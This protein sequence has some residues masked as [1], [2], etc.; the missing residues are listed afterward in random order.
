[1]PDGRD[2]T[3]APRS[4][5]PAT[6]PLLSLILLLGMAGTASAQEGASGDATDSAAAETSDP[7]LYTGAQ[8]ERGEAAFQAHCSACHFPNQF[9][10]EAF[11]VQWEG[12][13]AFDLVDQLRATMPYDN[14]GGL[15]AREYVDVAAYLLRLNRYP[16]GGK[17]LPREDARLREIRIP[18]KEEDAE[19]EAR[20]RTRCSDARTRSYSRRVD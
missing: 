5:A 13:T 10:G 8:A 4:L 1:M 7:G 18:E 15:P 14:P 19:G 9:R 2:M 17:E 12:R 6:T 20:S 16:E 11:T 3:R